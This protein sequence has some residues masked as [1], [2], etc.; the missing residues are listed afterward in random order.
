MSG[1]SVGMLLAKKLCG[2]NADTEND[3]LFDDYEDLDLTHSDFF[4]ENIDDYKDKIT[5]FTEQLYTFL[6]DEYDKKIPMQAIRRELTY[7]FDD[8]IKNGSDPAFI[9]FESVVSH[10]LE[11][12]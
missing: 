8:S 9:S 3:E 7:M 11:K 10:F 12:F 4:S 6:L 5:D 1:V 2:L